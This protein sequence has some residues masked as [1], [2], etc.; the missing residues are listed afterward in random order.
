MMNGSLLGKKKI[1]GR[2]STPP[3][4]PLTAL[5]LAAFSLTYWK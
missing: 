1:F 5:S 4:F 2:E 3:F